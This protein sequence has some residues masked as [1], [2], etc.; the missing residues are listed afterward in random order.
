MRGSKTAILSLQIVFSPRREKWL[1]AE[2]IG[3]LR[4]GNGFPSRRDEYLSISNR[5]EWR[6]F[7]T[8]LLCR[9]SIK[10]SAGKLC[11]GI[12]VCLL[13]EWGRV[14]AEAMSV[15]DYSLVLRHFV[16]LWVVY[17]PVLV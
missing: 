16:S 17:V 13:V 10:K 3:S 8:L 7:W 9:V 4:G 1:S 6:A 15:R 14:P 11:V 12:G 5:N 2:V